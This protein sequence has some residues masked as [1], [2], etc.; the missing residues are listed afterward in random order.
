M[1][2][3]SRPVIVFVCDANS[4]TGMGHFLRCIS[5]AEYLK[6]KGYQSIFIGDFSDSARSFADDYAIELQQSSRSVIDRV[7]RLPAKSRILL[8][9]Y[10]YSCSEL[11]INHYYLLIDDFCLQ[12]SYPVA[13]VINFTYLAQSY[14]Y[15]QKGAKTQA[16]GLTYYLAHP[17]LSEMKADFRQSVKRILVLIGSGDRYNIAQRLIIALRQISNT[18]FDIKVVTNTPPDK[19]VYGALVQ[20]VPLIS[21]VSLYYDWA[22]FCIT[23]GGLAK[24]ECAY[25][26]KPAAVISLTTAE[27]EETNSFAAEKL[28]FDLG[29]YSKLKTEN[30]VTALQQLLLQKEQ[31][32]AGYQACISAFKTHS[33]TAITDYAK[34]CWEL[35]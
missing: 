28:C 18:K 34:R 35:N 13:G 15:C 11:P 26:A 16:L 7:E 12:T 25:L 17:S 8:D 30:V 6:N 23:S 3:S 2:N 27:Q 1:N 33:S 21:N 32:L 31:R 22:D 19:H 14:N 5:L 29:F 9:S 20:F 10:N 4:I 24:Y